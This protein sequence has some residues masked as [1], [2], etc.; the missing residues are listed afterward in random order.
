MGIGMGIETTS[1]KSLDIAVGAGSESS[2]GCGEPDPQK[3]GATTANKPVPARAAAFIPND[4]L[5]SIRII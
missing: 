3:C 2:S 4:P 1:V 5:C